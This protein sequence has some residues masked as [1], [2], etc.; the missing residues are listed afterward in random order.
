MGGHK[1]I[2]FL[3]NPEV[4]EKQSMDKEEERKKYVL[5][6]SSYA[7]ERH[8]LWFTQ[9]ACTKICIMGTPKVGENECM[10]RR[11]KKERYSRD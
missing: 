9:A 5:T 4:V 7:C 1:T 2:R 8:H 6:I 3:V 11:R 10:E